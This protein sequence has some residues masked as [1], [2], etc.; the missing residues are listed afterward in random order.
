MHRMKAILQVKEVTKIFP[1]V[2]ALDKVD[3]TLNKGEIHA[4]CGENGAGKSTLM[5]ILSGNQQP[6]D[7]MLHLY[8]QE[9]VFANP[10]DAK[11]KGIGIV[12]QEKSLID[13]LSVADNI[14]AGNQPTNLFRLIDRRALNRLTNELLKSLNIDISPTVI[15]KNLPPAKQQMVEVAKSL[16]HQPKILILDEPT[17]AISEQ[18]TQ[19]LFELMRQLTSQGTSIIYISHRLQEIFEIADRVT[20]LKDG[21]SQGTYPIEDLDIDRI[22]KLM[23]G[24]D[25][26]VFDYQDHRRDSCALSV[27]HFS[28][29]AFHEISFDLHQGEIL[30]LA[31]LVG[32][33]RSELA[34][35]I[36]GASPHLGVIKIDGKN[37][38][39]P[40]PAA[41]IK[42]GLGYLPEDRKRQGLFLDMTVQENIECIYK[43]ASTSMEWEDEATQILNLIKTLNLKT[44][45]LQTKV[46]HLS[47]GNQQKIILA[48]WLMVNPEILMV[49][50]PTAGIDVGAKSE[51]YQIL[52]Q[53]SASGKSVLIISSE[54]PE[55][56]GL[57]DRILVMRHGRLVAEFDRKDFDEEEIV[58][59]ASG[60]RINLSSN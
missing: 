12:H 8:Q 38:N 28:G 48:K 3:F 30:G 54:L 5:N 34:Q 40:N 13:E 20:V 58:H 53:I 17:A 39:I 41:A 2:V 44:P 35:A 43:N 6:D 19:V 46:V 23:V 27:E 22:V 59:F 47:G 49:D 26:K 25:V 9:V 32:A 24:R 45:N 60:T 37:T 10:L 15:L 1:G 42:V 14:F 29:S 57:C 16:S 33:G 55:L 4:L 51:I 36:Y 31:G 7:G 21:V 52:N 18:D 11:Q 50:E 56:M